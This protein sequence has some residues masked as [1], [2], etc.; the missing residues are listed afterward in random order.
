[1]ADVQLTDDQEF[2]EQDILSHS[3]TNGVTVV[4]AAP[5]TG[6]TTLLTRVV[7]QL[8][9]G[10]KMA[11]IV[12]TPL[13][14]AAV[15][16]PAG[17]GPG[18]PD[19]TVTVAYL[20]TNKTL[21]KNLRGE[22]KNGNVAFVVI[23]IDEAFSCGAGEFDTVVHRA[24]RACKNTIASC[25]YVMVGDPGQ[26]QAV[27]AGICS[28][29][30]FWKMMRTTSTRL[31][32][33]RDQVRFL[34]DD[35]RQLAADL[36][37]KN[38]RGITEALASRTIDYRCIRMPSVGSKA[39]FLSARND[40]ADRINDRVVKEAAA[41]GQCVYR[42]I[43]R[44]TQR[45]VQSYKQGSQV[46]ITMNKRLPG[47]AEM[48]HANGD[49]GTLI[50][51]AGTYVDHAVTADGS[52][53]LNLDD[54]LRFTIDRGDDDFVT[55]AAERGR[56]DDGTKKKTLELIVAGGTGITFHKAQGCTIDHTV[57]VNLAHIRSYAGMV[58]ALTRQRT[59]GNLKVMPFDLNVV[60]TLAE[61][62]ASEHVETFMSFFRGRAIAPS[63]G[64]REAKRARTI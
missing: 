5:G 21:W 9:K 31:L 6:K 33:L 29:N 24:E 42:I 39:T 57:V 64:F 28:S 23:V 54:K 12:A 46:V 58:V 1:M 15:G 59:F 26:L 37:R 19:A 10:E 51:V 53:A 56:D 40:A 35:M 13:G 47:N 25:R 11:I 45:V 7:A 60:A 41:S 30:E 27:G 32:S 52:V 63:P 16:A 2:V 20:G 4:N 17:H 14:S 44:R 43:N 18:V 48:V 50:E 36:Q 55:V 22:I 8:R 38:V 61:M 3:L 34:D 62:P 49:R